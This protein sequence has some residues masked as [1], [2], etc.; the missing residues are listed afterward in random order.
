MADNGVHVLCFDGGGAR[1]YMEALIMD[2]IMRLVTIMK[3]NPARLFQHLKDDVDVVVRKSKGLEKIRKLM[4]NIETID[5]IHPTDVYNGHPIFNYI[6][7]KPT[8][9]FHPNSHQAL[10]CTNKRF[11]VVLPFF[12]LL[13]WDKHSYF[14]ISHRNKYWCFNC[15]CSSG[16]KRR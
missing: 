3:N 2:D 6:A 9:K 14:T 15:L 1:G 12:L 10:H 8:K 5:L 16:R 4:D 11:S 13:I 7:G